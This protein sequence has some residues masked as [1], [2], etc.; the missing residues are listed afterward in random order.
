MSFEK[1][2]GKEHL[3]KDFLEELKHKIWSTKGS[4]F[5]ADIRM[6]ETIPIF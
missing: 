3:D 6:K 5:R 1:G 4:R 2:E